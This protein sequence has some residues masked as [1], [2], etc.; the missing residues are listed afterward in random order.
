MKKEF[1]LVG[2]ME[3]GKE[4][5]GCIDKSIVFHRVSPQAAWIMNNTGDS[6]ECTSV[7]SS[8]DSLFHFH[9]QLIQWTSNEVHLTCEV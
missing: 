3:M 7:T 2:V 5:E 9:E 8:G 4:K 6:V 1:I